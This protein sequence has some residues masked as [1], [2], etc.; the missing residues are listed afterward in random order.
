MK[1]LL[2]GL[3]VLTLT[4]GVGAA[5][6]SVETPIGRDDVSAPGRDV[7]IFWSDDMEG[8]ENGWTHGDFTATGAPPRFHVDTY[9]A[10]GGSGSSWWC[11][12]FDYDADGGYGNSWHEYLTIPTTDVSSAG[13]YAVLTFAFRYDSEPTYD[14][15]YIQAESLGVWTV[16]ES[17][18][19]YGAWH[20]IGPYGYLI[21]A[22][23]SP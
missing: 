17:F 22:Y 12:S 13:A 18:N 2:I 3:A 14:F 9:M 4:A 8:G 21:G 10:F 5:R 23:D 1:R 20:D 6:L 11:G 19:G 15:T 7:V 16:L